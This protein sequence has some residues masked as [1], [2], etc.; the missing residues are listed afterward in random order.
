MET[1]P[2]AEGKSW[3]A[4]LIGTPLGWALSLAVAALGVY[5][6][7]AHTGHLFAALPY[8]LLVACPLMHL[9]GHGSHK[10]HRPDGK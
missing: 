5:L 10:H 9:F 3:R 6:L 7:V 4:R 2:Q 8:L 1:E